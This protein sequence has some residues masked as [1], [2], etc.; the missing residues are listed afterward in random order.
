MIQMTGNPN[1]KVS[2]NPEFYFS[3]F[4]LHAHTHLVWAATWMLAKLISS[5]NVHHC[6]L[7]LLLKTKKSSNTRTS[8]LFI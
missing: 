4:P 8:E 1:G 2:S 6:S 7:F 3:A 5:L